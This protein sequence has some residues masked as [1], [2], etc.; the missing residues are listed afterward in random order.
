MIRRHVLL[1]AGLLGTTVFLWGPM[2][3]L[4]QRGFRI[5]ALAAFARDTELWGALTQSL[6]LAVASAALSTIA[7][8]AIAF[9]L[10]SLPAGWRRIAF[11]AVAFPLVLPE[12][13][14]ALAMM[15]W[16]IRL[17]IPFGWTTLLLGHVG[18]T[19]SYAVLILKIS[20]EGLQ[21]SLVEAAR[22]CGA[23]GWSVFRHAI[24][25]Q[26]APAALASFISGFS[27]SLDDFLVSFFNKGLD[28]D[29]LPIRLYS[30]LRLK[31]APGLY[32]VSALLFC[33]STACVLVSQLWLARRSSPPSRS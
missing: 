1:W 6:L 14:I 2:A 33:L 27:L 21:W 24:W 7:G 25:P 20:V 31:V 3:L 10:P 26:I 4:L 9:G 5:E 8:T 11:A 19:L 13:A 18:F 17:G 23:R 12:I 15:V 30:A 32:A 22:D 28:Q 29:L 16:F